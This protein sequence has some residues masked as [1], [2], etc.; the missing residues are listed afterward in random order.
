M[1]I[2]RRQSSKFDNEIGEFVHN[3]LIGINIVRQTL[4]VPQAGGCG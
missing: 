1:A 4:L 3:I 2:C